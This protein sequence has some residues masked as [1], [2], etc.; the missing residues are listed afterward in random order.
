MK[1]VKFKQRIRAVT[2]AIAGFC[3][4]GGIAATPVLAD[5]T[6]QSPYMAKIVGQEDF[7]YVWTLGMEGLGDGQDKLVTID[8]NGTRRP[9][10]DVPISARLSPRCR[11]A[12][13]TRPITPVSL[14]IAATS[15]RVVWIPTRSSSSMFIPT[16]QN[17][18]CT[19]SSLTSLPKAVASWVRIPPTPCRDA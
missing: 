1:R 19:R 2:M 6:C 8:T 18:N 7:V 11:S 4:A 5:E 12:G 15:G 9:N 14:T 16:P 13:A 10:D 3:L 17:P